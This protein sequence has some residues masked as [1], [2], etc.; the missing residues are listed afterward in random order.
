MA[1]FWRKDGGRGRE[2]RGGI[3]HKR[4]Q[5]LKINKLCCCRIRKA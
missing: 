4:A 5:K 1:F 2:G 3:K